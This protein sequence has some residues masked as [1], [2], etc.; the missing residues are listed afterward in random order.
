MVL[1]PKDNVMDFDSIGSPDPVEVKYEGKT[2]W[3]HEP[4]AEAGTNY[5]NALLNNMTMGPNGRPTKVT[6][7]ASVEKTLAGDCLFTE[8]D[9][10]S[11]TCKKVGARELERWPTRVVKSLFEQA[12]KMGDLDEGEPD[13]IV[14]FRNA[15][16]LPSSPVSLKDLREFVGS[17]NGEYEDLKDWIKPSPEELAKN[18]L[19][20]TMTNS[21]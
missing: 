15:L 7:I 2:Y 16:A 8:Q 5:R 6:N 11:K 17:L 13:Y 21:A 14:Q 9:R 12:K 18:E 1:K 4:D 20:G 10:K 19:T 3:L